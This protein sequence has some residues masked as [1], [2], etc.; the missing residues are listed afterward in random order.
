[1]EETNIFTVPKNKDKLPEGDYFLIE[2]Y[3]LDKTCDCCKVMI[4]FVPRENRFLTLATIGYGWESFSFY[5]KWAY[6]EKD[7][8]SQMEGTHVEPGGVQSK[9]THFFLEQLNLTILRDKSFTEMIKY[10]YRLFKDVLKNLKPND[11]C[12]CGCGKKYSRF[13]AWK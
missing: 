12:P 11:P 13:H 10:H 5:K 8:A 9:Y 1:M 6:G 4:N 2:N 7:I 3:C